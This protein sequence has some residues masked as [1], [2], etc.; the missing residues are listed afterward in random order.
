MR[1]AATELGV[2]IGT[3]LNRLGDGITVQ[4]PMGQLLYANAAGARLCGFDTPEELLQATPEEVVSRFELFDEHGEPFPVTALPGRMAL[5]GEQPGEVLIRVRDRSS[6]ATRWSLVEAFAVKDESGEVAYAVNL[7]RD[8]TERTDAAA[9]ATLLNEVARVLAEAKEENAA[10]AR[11]FELIGDTL[12][13]DAALLFRTDGGTKLQAV[14][15]WG[16]AEVD[17]DGF[18]RG[19]RERT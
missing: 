15:V 9:R 16:G 19:M 1:P 8:V 2:D 6:G 10:L 12:G 5:Q 17:L 3:V 7:F 4:G 11:I 14:H 18:E 13:W